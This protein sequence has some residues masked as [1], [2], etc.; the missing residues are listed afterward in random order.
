[1]PEAF[2]RCVSKISR[3]KGAKDAYAICTA[4]NAG[5]VKQTRKTEAKKP[6]HDECMEGLNK[7]EAELLKEWNLDH[8]GV[9]PCPAGGCTYSMGHDGDH[10]TDDAELIPSSVG[11]RD[12]GFVNADI[13]PMGPV[14]GS[15]MACIC[16]GMC[17]PECT[18][19]SGC[20]RDCDC[21]CYDEAGPM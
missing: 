11:P 15:G 18:C 19:E 16:V 5:G 2:K 6:K 13:D 12:T 8:S 1:M 10:L 14:D 3:Q 21:L 9:R 4:A 20:C 7:I 17:G